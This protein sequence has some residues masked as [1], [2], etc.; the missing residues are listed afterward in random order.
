MS[1]ITKETKT[2]ILNC[3]NSEIEAF[4]RDINNSDKRT[5]YFGD[6]IFDIR[7]DYLTKLLKAKNEIERQ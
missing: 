4:R 2:I 7:E 6:K 5:D 1:N 3:L